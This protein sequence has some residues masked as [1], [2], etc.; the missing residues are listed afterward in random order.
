MSPRPLS[1]G[2]LIFPGFPMAC[3]TSMIEPLRAANEI[4]QTEAFAWRLVGVSEARVLSSA[5]VAFEPDQTLEEA[6][7]LDHLFLL[8]SP[9]AQPSAHICAQL[10]SLARHGTSLGAVSGGVFPLVRSG[11]AEGQVVSVH[12]CYSAAFEAEFPASLASSQLV[13]I[14]PRCITAAGAAAGFDVALHL[15]ETRLGS[16]TATEVAC[17]FQHPMLRRD[18]VQQVVPLLARDS[19]ETSLPAMLSRVIAQI[20]QDL[21]APPSVAT[22]AHDLGVSPR[23]VERMF[24]RATGQSPTRYIRSLRMKAARQ[25]VMYSNERMA[26]IAASVGYASARP[27]SAHYLSEFGGKYTL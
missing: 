17:W 5:D 15:I 1:V 25:M 2:F 8:S 4:S 24:K 22:M 7:G 6:E 27:F 11:A 13:E 19:T 10:R 21:A 3:L 26:D 23:H 18:G 20:T 12:W 16:T 14:A 9:T